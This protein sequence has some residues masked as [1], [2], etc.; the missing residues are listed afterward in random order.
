[1]PRISWASS[2]RRA[3]T[4]HDSVDSLELTLALNRGNGCIRAVGLP[5]EE[6]LAGQR[7]Q[8]LPAGLRVK[9]QQA[10][11]LCGREL[12]AGHLQIF[13]ADAAQKLINRGTD[14]ALIHG[15]LPRKLK[16][17]GALELNNTAQGVTVLTPGTIV[18]LLESPDAVA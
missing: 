11:R 17:P 3:K 7:V 18:K 15:N 10:L 9:A 6:P 4:A 12:Q 14:E 1:M 8:K 13:A 5:V 16:V 2:P